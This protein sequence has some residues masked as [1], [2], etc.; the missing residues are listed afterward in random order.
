MRDWQIDSFIDDDVVAFT[1]IADAV[2]QL[3]VVAVVWTATLAD[4]YDLIHL[5]AHWVW[6][7]E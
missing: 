7:L 2:D 5:C 1:L 4:W 6:C 3:D